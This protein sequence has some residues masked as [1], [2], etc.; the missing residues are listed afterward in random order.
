MGPL[1][2]ISGWTQPISLPL[3]LQRTLG[4]FR[5]CVPCHQPC[6]EN[7]GHSQCKGAIGSSCLPSWTFKEASP[8]SFL[9]NSSSTFVHGQ[10]MERC[11]VVDSYKNRVWYPWTGSVTNLVASRWMIGA[12]GSCVILSSG[13]QTPHPPSLHLRSYACQLPTFHTQS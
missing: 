7:M 10:G 11:V 5:F 8:G 3:A 4:S 6:S 2:E 9:G 1:R 12:T 13:Y